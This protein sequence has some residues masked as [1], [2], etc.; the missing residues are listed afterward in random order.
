MSQI[1]RLTLSLSEF[2][3]ILI[4]SGGGLLKQSA[5]SGSN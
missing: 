5:D 4:R 2:Y 3:D 1:K